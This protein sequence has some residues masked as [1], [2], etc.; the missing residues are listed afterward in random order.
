[1]L[2]VIL[3]LYYTGIMKKKME[4]TIIYRIISRDILLIVYRL[5]YHVDREE[6]F[7][8]GGGEDTG[9]MQTVPVRPVVPGRRL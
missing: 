3:G 7:V 6:I 2:R 5:L 9:S 1:M 8:M 4:S